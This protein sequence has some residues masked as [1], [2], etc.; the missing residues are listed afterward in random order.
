MQHDV[1]SFQENTNEIRLYG[2]HQG[3]DSNANFDAAFDAVIV[4]N[5]ARSELRPKQWVKL[6]KPYPWGAAWTIVPECQ[7][8]NPEILH[9][10]Y[11]K[12]NVM[13]G[14]LPTGMIPQTQ[15]QRLSSVFWSLPTEQLHTFM[16][17]PPSEW[18]PHIRKRWALVETGW[19]NCPAR[20]INRFN[21]F[22]HIIGMW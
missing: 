5:G 12:S 13:M 16:T 11:D 4:A 19:N 10:F 7:H 2:Q 17:Q 22:L 15:S 14:I 9:Q 8:L 3:H 18:I 21:G 20:P 6:D 1:L